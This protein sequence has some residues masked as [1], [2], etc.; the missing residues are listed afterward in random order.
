MAKKHLGLANKN[1]ESKKQLP[2]EEINS[3]SIVDIVKYAYENGLFRKLKA[4]NRKQADTIDLTEID[5]ARLRGYF[6]KRPE[7]KSEDHYGSGIYSVEF[8]SNEFDIEIF[9]SFMSIYRLVD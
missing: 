5:S 4:T 7:F 6:G 8:I 3:V 2:N 9:P 1:A